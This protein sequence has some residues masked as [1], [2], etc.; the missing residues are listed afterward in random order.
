LIEHYELLA[1][2]KSKTSVRVS[3]LPRANEVSNGVQG[4]L[5]AGCKSSY[6]SFKE[7]QE[8]G[9]DLSRFIKLSGKQEL[10]AKTPD[11]LSRAAGNLLI[12]LSLLGTFI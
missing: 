10:L 4:L 12:L 3:R 1:L 7:G 6:T 11:S 2:T 8:R 5:R 9:L